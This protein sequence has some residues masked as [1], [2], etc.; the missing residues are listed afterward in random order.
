MSRVVPL[1]D[2]ERE[3]LLRQ[4]NEK[5]RIQRLL[6]TRK[7]AKEFAK[8]TRTAYKHQLQVVT[9]NMQNILREELHQQQQIQA[10]QLQVPYGI[11]MK[12][13]F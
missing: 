5:L 6:E 1:T 2:T 13:M 9:E 8:Q 12:S 11:S 10:A 4:Q 3:R 7:R